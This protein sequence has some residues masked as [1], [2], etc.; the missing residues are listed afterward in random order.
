[1]YAFFM[2]LL[3]FFDSSWLFLVLFWMLCIT[4]GIALIIKFFWKTPRPKKAKNVRW[5]WQ[6]IDQSSFPSVHA[7]RAV[8]LFVIAII[9]S[10]LPFQI[11][12]GIFMVLIVFSRIQLKA[13]YWRDIIGGVILG[14]IAGLAAF[15]LTD[16][17]VDWLTKPEVIV[18]EIN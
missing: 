5:W 16:I 9:W 13:H 8:A 2:V 3:F 14:I 12:A 17:I 1:M 11:V 6:R 10:N 15:Y 18:Y 7:A 4:T